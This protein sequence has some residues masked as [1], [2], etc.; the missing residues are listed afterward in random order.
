MK[1]YLIF[2]LPDDR[3]SFMAAAKS[4]DMAIALFEITS[5]LKRHAEW[6]LEGGDKTAGELLDYIFD[7][8][9]AELNEQGID[10]DQLTE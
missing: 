2:N 7:E 9:H 3:T 6:W 4:G 10:I 1:A 5:N 8:I